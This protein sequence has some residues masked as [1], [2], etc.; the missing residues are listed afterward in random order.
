MFT[1]SL[2]GKLNKITRDFKIFLLFIKS[3]CC[4][5][6]IGN[7]CPHNKPIKIVVVTGLAPVT[8]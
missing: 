1:F 2:Y 4:R 6:V 3:L 8:K 5:G 7:V